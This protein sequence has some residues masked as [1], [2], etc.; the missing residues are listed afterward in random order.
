MLLFNA[1][2]W[3]YFLFRHWLSHKLLFFLLEFEFVHDIGDFLF[4]C[5]WLLFA[6]GFTFS[7]RLSLRFFSFFQVWTTDVFRLWVKTWK[8][9][10]VRFFIQMQR[11]C[12]LWVFVYIFMHCNYII[13]P[14][15]LEWFLITIN[16]ILILLNGKVLNKR[17]L[18]LINQLGTK[19][20]QII[21]KHFSSVPFIYP[22]P[23]LSQL[24][25]SIFMIV[26]NCLA[27]RTSILLSCLFESSDSLRSLSKFF[28]KS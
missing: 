25:S 17:F 3:R 4:I 16:R 28:L 11:L 12:S 13:N 14:H 20:C 10:S 6:I 7:V 18:F 21:L 9:D 23:F 15:R 1:Y 27:E 5:F 8:F 2:P 19:Y 26:N 24:G 22:S